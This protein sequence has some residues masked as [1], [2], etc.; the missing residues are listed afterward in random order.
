M[1]Y[2]L[3][4][5]LLTCGCGEEAEEKV[6]PE[7][8]V[9]EVTTDLTFPEPDSEGFWIKGQEYKPPP[10]PIERGYR[11]DIETTPQGKF[12]VRYIGSGMLNETTYYVDRLGEIRATPEAMNKA[13]Y[14]GIPTE[15]RFH[16]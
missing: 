9:T 8:E 2:L 13:G 6:S 15:I 3:I 5:L 11:I 10:P 12:E 7:C 14:E 16:H 4:A 1:R